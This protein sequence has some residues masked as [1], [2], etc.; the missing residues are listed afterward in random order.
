MRTCAPGTRVVGRIRRSIVEHGLVETF[1]RVIRRCW[2]RCVVSVEI[3]SLR[4]QSRLCSDLVTGDSDAIVSLTAYGR[5]VRTVYLTIES[6]ARGTTRPRALILWLDDEDVLSSAP[7][8]LRR[9]VD[10]GLEIRY[11]PPL[12]SHKK[13]FPA[14]DL[15]IDRNVARLVTVD[16]DVLY[17]RW[18]LK[19]LMDVA[20]SAPSAVVAYRARRVPLTSDGL[21]PW[22]EWPLCR[23]VEPSLLHFG[24][25]EAGIAYP[26]S[27]IRALKARGLGFLSIAPR[28]D[29]VWL[30]STAVSAGIPTRQVMR[31][32]LHPLIVPGSQVV[33]LSH[34]NISLGGND[35]A[36]GASYGEADISLLRASRI[37]EDER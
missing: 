27:V 13:Y 15:A 6:I 37:D 5:R 29:D 22:A 2:R 17:P 28:A 19:R 7:P 20:Q 31:R 4:R 32:A 11:A 30:H 35:E 23:S 33:A 34:S 16:D 12:G 14:L 9:L 8:E 18:W 24:I 25:G 3:W 26:Q 21:A 1:S 10:R 36:L